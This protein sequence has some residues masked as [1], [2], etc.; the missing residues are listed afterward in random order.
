MNLTKRTL[1]LG[2]AALLPSIAHA[3]AGKR[4]V[5]AWAYWDETNYTFISATPMLVDEYDYSAAV[6]RF[7]ACFEAVNNTNYR[8]LTAGTP[9]DIRCDT[10]E[11]AQAEIS[12][13]AAR[14]AARG[15]SVGMVPW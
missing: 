10:A 11:A 7:R 12:L 2:F 8:N 9:G 3:Q 1:A 13:F 6:R 15:Q 14:E 4:W 5:F